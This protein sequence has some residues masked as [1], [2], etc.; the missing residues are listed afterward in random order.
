V[1]DRIVV[2]ADGGAVRRR[3]ERQTDRQ[4]FVWDNTDGGPFGSELM[5]G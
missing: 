1:R 3:R 2:R 5:G 4:F